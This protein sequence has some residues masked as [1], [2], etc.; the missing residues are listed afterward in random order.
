MEEV[1]RHVSGNPAPRRILDFGCGTGNTSALLAASFPQAE[2]CGVDTSQPAL[3]SARERFGDHRTRF[4]SASR[5]SEI[6][7]FDLAY[8]NG[9]FHHISP[10]DRGDW[11]RSIQMALHPGGRLM[12]F[13]NNP[14][15]PA[16]RLVMHRI[17]F[18]RDAIMIW[19]RQAGHLL[20]SGG[21]ATPY[22]TRFLFIFP[23]A[24][25]WLRPT[26]P[27]FSRLPLGAQYLVVGERS[28]P[29]HFDD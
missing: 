24:L 26:E 29:R 15:S 23:R 7:L 1:L 28:E 6:G 10:E 17:P 11:V 5:I 12:F 25:G 22:P 2:V 18:D 27:L 4:E 16:A 9:V 8:V 19:P 3:Q 14:Y 21:F 20:R 13:E